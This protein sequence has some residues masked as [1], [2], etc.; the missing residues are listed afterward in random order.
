MAFQRIG[1]A[2]KVLREKRKLSLRD[3][4]ELLGISHLALHRIEQGEHY[5]AAQYAGLTRT[6][7]PEFTELLRAETD[8]RHSLDTLRVDAEKAAGEIAADGAPDEAVWTGQGDAPSTEEVAAKLAEAYDAVPWR[9]I[10]A[11]AAI[12]H[13]LGL[14]LFDLDEDRLAVLEKA[15]KR[16]CGLMDIGETPHG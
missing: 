8:L 16:W 13:R 11:P 12:A 7:G 1:A 2:V 9:E 14:A 5:L 15:S 6:L 4:A 10:L 3:L